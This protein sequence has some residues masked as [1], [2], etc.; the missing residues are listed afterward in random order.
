MNGVLVVV[1]ALL[2]VCVCVT[3]Q[4]Y[5][6]DPTLLLG[7]A[8]ARF[9]AKLCFLFVLYPACVKSAV[10][11][12]FSDSDASLLA[13]AFIAALPWALLVLACA[14][15][16]LGPHFSSFYVSDELCDGAADEPGGGRLRWRARSFSH[17]RP[18]TPTTHSGALTLPQLEGTSIVPA[19]VQMRGDDSSGGEASSVASS[20]ESGRHRTGESRGDGCGRALRYAVWP[21][22]EWFNQKDGAISLFWERFGDLFTDHRSGVARILPVRACAEHCVQRGGGLRDRDVELPDG[23]HRAGCA[24]GGRGCLLSLPLARTTRA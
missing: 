6:G 7:M 14:A 19:D 12:F 3:V 23:V 9:P 16:L 10:V 15:I 5:R 21:R 11:I 2:H 24:D 1:A 18:S 22:G 8:V 4:R 17:G 20:D 13:V